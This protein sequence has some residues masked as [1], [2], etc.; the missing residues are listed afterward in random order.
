MP[1]RHVAVLRVQSCLDLPLLTLEED[2][3]DPR[4]VGQWHSCDLGSCRHTRVYAT[5]ARKS[6]HTQHDIP[7]AN[8]NIML[9]LA[10]RGSKV[11]T[12]T[13]SAGLQKVKQFWLPAWTFSVSNLGRQGPLHLMDRI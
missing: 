9:G 8:D 1:V 7:P 11:E 6:F 13:N 10:R 5:Q 2:N 3:N 4:I 12:G